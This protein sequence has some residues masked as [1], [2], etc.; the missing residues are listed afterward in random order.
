MKI[1][2]VTLLEIFEN[3]Y[4]DGNA[5]DKHLRFKNALEEHGEVMTRN[6]AKALYNRI[7]YNGVA[8]HSQQSEETKYLDRLTDDFAGKFMSFAL[9][10][11]SLNLNTDEAIARLCTD[12]AYRIAKE[13]VE[14]RHR[15]MTE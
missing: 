14:A 7:L 9:E 8:Y 4:I 2:P 12:T 11:S 13:M 3:S 15:S 10:N 5:L 6:E 1:A